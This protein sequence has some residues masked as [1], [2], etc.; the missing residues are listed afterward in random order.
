[1]TFECIVIII[2][3]EEELFIFNYINPTSI[4]VVNSYYW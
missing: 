1:M 2:V 4:I 3:V